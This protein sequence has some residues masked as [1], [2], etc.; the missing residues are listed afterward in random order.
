MSGELSAADLEPGYMDLQLTWS[1]D[2]GS[3]RRRLDLAFDPQI[4][5]IS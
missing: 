4:S 3:G 1:L 2:I 5:A